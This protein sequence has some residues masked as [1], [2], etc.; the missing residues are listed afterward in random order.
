MG[1]VF[2]RIAALLASEFKDL[3]PL[4]GPQTAQAAAAAVPAEAPPALAMADGYDVFVSYDRSVT[5]WIIDFIE[6]LR[7]EMALRHARSTRIF[8]DIR[9]VALGSAWQDEVVQALRRSKVMLALVSPSYFMRSVS[10][11]EFDAFL[12]REASEARPRII[13]VIVTGA[14][15][16][17]REIVTSDIFKRIQVFD[18][19]GYLPRVLRI[20]ASR[21]SVGWQQAL[22]E[23]AKALEPMIK[24]PP[25]SGSTR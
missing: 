11:R 21:R 4:V 12:A 9:E 16:D 15:R 22:F 14:T 24:R 3:T 10:R 6:V 1:F 8:A 19:R 25:P 18:L 13:A 23:L 5:E 7:E 20:P 2:D 17:L